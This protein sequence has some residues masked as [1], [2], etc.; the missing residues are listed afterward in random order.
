MLKKISEDGKIAHAHGSVGLTGKGA[1]LP[2]ATYRFNATPIKIPTHTWDWY[3]PL[4]EKTK[5]PG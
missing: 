1:I 2:E 3:E 4:Y 5:T